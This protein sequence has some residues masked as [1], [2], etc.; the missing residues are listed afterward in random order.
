M[1]FPAPKAAGKEG[2][3]QRCLSKTQTLL[4]NSLQGPALIL[5][6]PCSQLVIDDQD[7]VCLTQWHVGIKSSYVGTA[8]LKLNQSH[9]P[10]LH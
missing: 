7:W 9:M 3:Q 1:T 5:I 10:A 6:W 2:G 4:C 8:L